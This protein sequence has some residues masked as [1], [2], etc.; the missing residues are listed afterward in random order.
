MQSNVTIFWSP[1]LHLIRGI[2]KM[3]TQKRDLM[4][5]QYLKPDLGLSTTLNF[6]V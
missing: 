2:L 5:R 1:S 6:L 4:S 3:H